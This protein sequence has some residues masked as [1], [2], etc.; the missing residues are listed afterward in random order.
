MHMKIF[1]RVCLSFLLL[2]FLVPAFDVAAQSDVVML[3]AVAWSPDGETL[4]F[5]GRAISGQGAVWLYDRRGVA[6]DTIYLPDHPVMIRWS[7]DGRRLAVRYQ[8]QGG[9]QLSIW[10]WEALNTGAPSV[11]TEE[12]RGPSAGDQIAWSPTGRYVAVDDSL[13]VYIIDAATGSPVAQLY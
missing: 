3:F 1:W 7:R 4:A 8:V 9:T 11:T 13:S 6:I 10:D 5:G 12:I 2:M